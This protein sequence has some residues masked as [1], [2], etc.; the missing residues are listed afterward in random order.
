MPNGYGAEP[1]MKLADFGISKTLKTGTDDYTNSIVT[2]PSETMGWMAPEG[3]ESKR[4]DSKA[5]IFPLGCIFAYTLRQTH[6]A[7]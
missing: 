7:K 6:Q 5:D 1:L 4:L 2:D 3:Y